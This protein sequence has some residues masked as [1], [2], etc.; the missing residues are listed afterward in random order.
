MKTGVRIV[1]VLLFCAVLAVAVCLLLPISR[2]APPTP[3]T[4]AQ[5]PSLTQTEAPVPTQTETAA[6]PETTEPVPD[7]PLLRQAE[8]IAADMTL[9]E[10]LCQLM[11]LSPDTLSGSSP[12][13]AVGE[14]MQTALEEY[15]VCGFSF[16]QGNLRTRDQTVSML[17]DL[18][19]MA[20]LGLFFCVDEE[21][22]TVWRVMGNPQMGTTRLDSMFSYREEGGATAYRNAETIAEELSLLGFNVDFAPVADVWSNPDNTVI[23]TRAY[24]DDNT[25][26]AEL[27]AQAVRGF[28]AGNIA[29]TLKHFPGHGDT[30][31]DTHKGAAT[32]RRT[33][34]DLYAGELLPFRAGIEAGADLVMIGHLSVP[35]LDPDEPATFSYPI[36]TEL[37]RG[38][39]GFDGVVITDSLGMGALS[40]YSEAERCQKALAAG[41]DILLGITNP[42]E[43][44]EALMQAVESGTLTQERID[45]SVV[46]ILKLKLSRGILTVPED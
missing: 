3:E 25:Q 4:T 10:K 2:T 12:T 22:G 42:E 31:E 45:E 7:D 24:S 28:H 8:Q 39:L 38:E 27:V 23:G 44:L 6:E 34:E 15:P 17:S 16:G 26:A 41:C 18:Q 36:V 40:R 13:T 21:G 1:F 9:R 35:A 43:T 46:R 30:A 20:T 19:S 5:I 33:K 11:I 37:L 14:A 32:V 29:C